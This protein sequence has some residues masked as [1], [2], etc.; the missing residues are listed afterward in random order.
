[1]GD[2]ARTAAGE[3]ALIAGE[4]GG[5]MDAG[6]GAG[7]EGTDGFSPRSGAFSW[8]LLILRARSPSEVDG[9]PAPMPSPPV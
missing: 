4:V 8:R 7:D 2:G 6:A 1:M 9:S 5:G 3:V